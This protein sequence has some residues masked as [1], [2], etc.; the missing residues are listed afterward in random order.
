MRQDLSAV[1]NRGNG[2][3]FKKTRLVLQ[4]WL[5]TAWDAMEER[6]QKAKR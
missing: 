3:V 5:P 4:V 6:E 2:A 1:P